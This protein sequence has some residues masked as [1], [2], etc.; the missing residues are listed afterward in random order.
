MQHQIAAKRV[1]W[2]GEAPGF[3][4]ALVQPR[5]AFVPRTRAVAVPAM[6]LNMILGRD[7]E[8][9]AAVKI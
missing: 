6:I 5:W 4:A 1:L 9:F 2:Q 7:Y 8:R 3:A